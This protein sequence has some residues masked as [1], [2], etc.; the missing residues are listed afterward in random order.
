M[1][2]SAIGE[3][4]SKLPIVVLEHNPAGVKEI[5]KYSSKNNFFVNL[6]LSG[7]FFFMY[8]LTNYSNNI[9]FLLFK[10]IL[11]RVNIML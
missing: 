4:D 5:M 7:K 10:V 6:I 2:V 11:M 8:K 9:K 3:C 1:N